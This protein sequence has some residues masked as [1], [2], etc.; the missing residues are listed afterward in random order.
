MS[1]VNAKYRPPYPSQHHMRFPYSGLKSLLIYIWNVT[2]YG[3]KEKHCFTMY[4]IFCVIRLA[5]V[6]FYEFVINECQSHCCVEKMKKVE[7]SLFSWSTS[8]HA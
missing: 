8:F 5:A 1:R 6:D 7:N 3:H 4:C 2:K